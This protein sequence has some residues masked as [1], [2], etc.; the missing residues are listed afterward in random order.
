MMILLHLSLIL[1]DLL[2]P[3]HGPLF[4]INADFLVDRENTVLRALLVWNKNLTPKDREVKF[5]AVTNDPF[6]FLRGTNHLFYHDMY[7]LKQYDKK[8]TKYSQTT[9]IQGDLHPQNFGTFD[10][11]ASTVAFNVN[12]FDEAVVSDYQ[13][14]LWRFAASMLLALAKKN[15]TKARTDSLIDSF[16]EGYLGEVA[17]AADGLE[18]ATFTANTV[19]PPLA[20]FLTKVERENSRVKMLDRWA[21]IGSNGARAFDYAKSKGKLSPAP[22]GIVRLFRGKGFVDYYNSL[23]VISRAKMPFN[24]L[25]IKDVAARNLAGTGSLGAGRYYVLVEGPSP[26]QQDDVILD[27]KE[28]G[29]PAPFFYMGEKFMSQYTE[30]FNDNDAY[31]HNIGLLSL[32]REA[33]PFLGYFRQ[34]KKNDTYSVRQRSPWKKSL[35]LS[36]YNYSD[37]LQLTIQFGQMIGAD[38]AKASNQHIVRENSTNTMN[39]CPGNFAQRMRTMLNITTNIP[40]RPQTSK[41]AIEFAHIVKKIGY[42]YANRTMEDFEIFRAF[43]RKVLNLK[44]CNIL[45]I[46]NTTG[47][48]R[49]SVRPHGV[50]RA[51]YISEPPNEGTGNEIPAPADYVPTMAP[52]V[53]AF[54]AGTFFASSII[55]FVFRHDLFR[56]DSG[57]YFRVA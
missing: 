11:A 7:V 30:D 33:D 45:S 17:Q 46:W 14:D 6:Y 20:E 47:T 13:Y 29:R 38:H 5:C 27:I 10:T 48:S 18:H 23:T 52:M 28:Q 25:H 54:F 19:V 15:F 41:E 42:F 26:S 40:Q 53:L 44:D 24:H 8:L 16:I 32:L 2:D 22:A 43:G 36:K 55:L 21:P 9:W 49:K 56:E 50:P 3:D 51:A 34:P 31:R 37:L 1:A 12:D 35:E 57:D 39:Y 4:G